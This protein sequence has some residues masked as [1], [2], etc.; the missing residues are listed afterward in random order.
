[1]RAAHC[2]THRKQ[3]SA[4]DRDQQADSAA[5]STDPAKQWP[6]R[7]DIFEHAVPARP[8]SEQEETEGLEA[9]AE[10][11]ELKIPLRSKSRRRMQSGDRRC[12]VS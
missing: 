2:A 4:G 12:V 1:L 8:Q 9:A 7:L 5:P 11:P 6:V 10:E 3:H